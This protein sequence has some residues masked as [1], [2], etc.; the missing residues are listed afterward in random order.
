MDERVRATSRVCTIKR[1]YSGYE[2]ASEESS[3][4]PNAQ[5]LKGKDVIEPKTKRTASL[6]VPEPPSEPH[7]SP[8]SNSKDMGSYT[9]SCSKTT[10]L[11]TDNMGRESSLNLP[12]NTSSLNVD[13]SEQSTSVESIYNI[14]MTGSTDLSVLLHL[15][16]GDVY[17]ALRNQD[18]KSRILEE[19]INFAFDKYFFNG[20][21]YTVV[22]DIN[23]L[24]TA[25]VNFNELS[26]PVESS[27]LYQYFVKEDKGCCYEHFK[28]QDG[29]QLDRKTLYR[30]T[31]SL[32]YPK[33]QFFSDNLLNLLDDEK[34]SERKYH[35]LFMSFALICGL[36]I[37]DGSDTS[38]SLKSNQKTS[39]PDALVKGFGIYKDTDGS[40]FVT[41]VVAV[42][43]AKRIYGKEDEERRANNLRNRTIVPHQCAS[44]VDDHVKAQHI[45]EMLVV[46]QSGQSLFGF[47]GIYGLLV[48]ETK[49]T[50]VYYRGTKEYFQQISL[51]KPK[52]TAEV[53][54][55]NHFNILARDGRRTLISLLIDM[56]NFTKREM[57]KKYCR[58]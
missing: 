9:D 10:D 36:R 21:N 49:V 26:K 27:M 5:I 6:S 53:L 16:F 25:K 41:K 34:K 32:L 38:S 1:K 2:E 40:H 42:V 56:E 55:S 4:A 50:L 22:T 29:N 15:G 31:C 28:D 45:G 30:N 39:T 54:Y 57:E 23:K 17:T 46:V 48:Q 11:S 35:Q 13:S 47:R 12:P 20:D 51:G 43:E 18:L 3:N 8:N 37:F 52:L 24:A 33:L 19:C 58:M 44:H 7:S 14:A